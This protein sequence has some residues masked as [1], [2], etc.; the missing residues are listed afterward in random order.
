MRRAARGGRGDHRQDA[1]CPS[2]A[3][4]PFTETATWGAT[5]NP[6]DPQ[7]APGGSSGGSAAAVAAG[8]VGAA[9][10]GDGAG[11]IRIPAAWCGLFGLKPQRGRVSP[12]R[13][14]ALAWPDG[15]RRADVLGGRH[16]RCFTTW[17]PARTDVDRARAP[18][19]PS[20]V[21]A[22]RPRR[23]PGGCA[24]RCPRKSRGIIPRLDRG[25]GARA[26]TDRRAAAARSGTRSHE[27][28]PDYG[29]ARSRPC[30][31]ASCAGSRRGGRRSPSRAPGTAHALAGAAGGA[32]STGAVCSARWAARASCT[33]RLNGVLDD[34]D[35]LFTPGRRAA[36]RASA[37]CRAAVR[38]GRSNTVAGW[39]PTTACWNV[40]G[41]PAC[42]VPAGL[43][44]GRPAARGAARR[45]AERRGDA[46]VAGRAD[47]G[48]A[49]LGAGSPAWLLVSATGA[50]GTEAADELLE[51]AVEAARMAGGLLLER[52]RH[53]GEQ[54]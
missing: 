42:S 28:D 43:H 44:R 35:V 50:S 31:P 22:V 21:R 29:S 13:T 34:H 12:R 2:W 23:R 15:L 41:Q 6:W 37:R 27:R 18:V 5:R 39:C 46:A 10:A 45:Q 47:R 3:L 32:D 33:A 11:S 1:T 53:G 4:W 20:P 30:S 16:A 38:C 25:R 36:R 51:L 52:V 9:L 48:R 7:R 19:P 26:G 17:S 40:T 49:P 54:A 8:L 14:R 24:S